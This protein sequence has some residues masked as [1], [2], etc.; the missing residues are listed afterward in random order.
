MLKTKREQVEFSG[1][2]RTT[3]KLAACPP[4]S[5]PSLA[6]QHG[7]LREVGTR[8]CLPR[9]VLKCSEAQWF[10]GSD[11]SEIDPSVVSFAAVLRARSLQRL[12]QEGLRNPFHN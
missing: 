4:A 10:L 9:T 11:V 2:S 7:R 6:W 3:G 12:V 8:S 5:P 1:L